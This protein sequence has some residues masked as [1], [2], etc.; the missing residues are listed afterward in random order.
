MRNTIE[1]KEYQNLRPTCSQDSYYECLAKQFINGPKVRNMSYCKQEKLCFPFSLPS[2]D[3][4]VPVCQNPTVGTCFKNV[5]LD[6][7]KDPSKYC[8]SSCSVKEFRT[9]KY[10]VGRNDV[11]KLQLKFGVP[12]SNR[13]LRSTKPF[14]YVYQEYYITSKI[15]L[16][17]IVGGIFGTFVGMSF[18]TA[19]K[20]FLDKLRTCY[21]WVMSKICHTKH[22]TSSRNLLRKWKA[23]DVTLLIACLAAT[24]YFARE[25]V[26]EYLSGKTNYSET[27]ELITLQDLPTLTVCLAPTANSEMVGGTSATLIYSAITNEKVLFN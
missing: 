3:S 16:I 12:A 23:L 7:E 27:E 21:S 26:F 5:L 18:L 10:C 19:S 25:S 24:S 8:L 2:Y 22:Q 9:G 20:W 4:Q 17:G 14:K 15:A 1:V 6:I 11:T 13:D